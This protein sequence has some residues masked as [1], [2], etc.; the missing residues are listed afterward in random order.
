M[1]SAEIAVPIGILV[2]VIIVG[3]IVL[4][5]PEWQKAEL[6]RDLEADLNSIEDCI[7]LVDI[8]KRNQQNWDFSIS[9]DGKPTAYYVIRT[10]YME[11]CNDE[12]PINENYFKEHMLDFDQYRKILGD[13]SLPREE[14]LPYHWQSNLAKFSNESNLGWCIN[15]YYDGYEEETERCYWLGIRT[16]KIPDGQS[17]KADNVISLAGGDYLQIRDK[18]IYATVDKSSFDLALI[19]VQNCANAGGGWDDGCYYFVGY[20]D[21]WCESPHELWSTTD[22]ENATC[23]GDGQLDDLKNN[24]KLKELL[25]ETE[26]GRATKV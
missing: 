12:L 11:N 23:Y 8:M 20:D 14:R 26:S 9:G 4:S 19:Q 3:G 18:K 6:Q 10:T 21:R 13:G 5:T 2:I 25:Q 17:L 22:K 16:E 1:A 15:E 24:T 7:E